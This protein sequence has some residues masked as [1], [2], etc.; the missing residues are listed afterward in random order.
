MRGLVLPGFAREGPTVDKK[1]WSSVRTAGVIYIKREVLEGP[2]VGADFGH[3]LAFFVHR[4]DIPIED[5]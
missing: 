2:V 4:F 3:A 1:D 5:S